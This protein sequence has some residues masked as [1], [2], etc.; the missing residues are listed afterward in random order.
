MQREAP[1]W[2]QGSLG[3]IILERL[4]NKQTKTSKNT[5]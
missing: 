1:R 4:K 5:L 3:I 2:K